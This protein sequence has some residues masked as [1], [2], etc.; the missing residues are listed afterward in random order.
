MN[1]GVLRGSPLP[2]P[3]TGGRV[4]Y[5]YVPNTAGL[6]HTYFKR[7]FYPQAWK[8]AII[9]DERSIHFLHTPGI[10]G[11]ACY[12]PFYDFVCR[13]GRDTIGRSDSASRRPL[14]NHAAPSLWRTRATP[15]PLAAAS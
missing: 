10:D 14:S 4:A 8:D 11:Q 9:V 6:G 7:Y 12:S 15:N 1:S 5:V 3:A 13:Q 2:R